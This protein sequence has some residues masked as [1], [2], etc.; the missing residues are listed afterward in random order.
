[1]ATQELYRTPVTTALVGSVPEHDA[2]L[3]VLPAEQDRAIVALDG[4]VDKTQLAIR[5]MAAKTAD[6]V[7]CLPC[8]SFRVKELLLD[9]SH[10]GHAGKR[11]W[12]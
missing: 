3:S 5:D 8:A 10:S 6:L 11:W 2:I 12:R 7:P 4:E 9:F 1:V